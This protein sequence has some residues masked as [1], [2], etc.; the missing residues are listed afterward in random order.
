[1]RAIFFFFQA[2]DGIRDVAVTGVQ[3]CALPI[4][5]SVVRHPQSVAHRAG[6]DAREREA[7]R[8][9]ERARV[10]LPE[11]PRQSG[12]QLVLLPTPRGGPRRDAGPAGDALERDLRAPRRRCGEL[13]CL[14]PEPVRDVDQGA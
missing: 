13:S 3:T 7:G 8:P 4:S 9:A 12:E 14:A 5:S 1:M 11:T 6:A 10:T 2:E